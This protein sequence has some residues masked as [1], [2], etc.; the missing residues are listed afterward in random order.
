MGRSRGG[1]TTKI[2][3]LVDAMGLPIALKLARQMADHVPADADARTAKLD[4]A[5]GVLLALSLALE[6]ILG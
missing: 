6:A 2:H 5:F 3:A 1:L 4:T